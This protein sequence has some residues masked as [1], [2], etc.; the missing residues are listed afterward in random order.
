MLTGSGT[1][2]PVDVTPTWAVP[3]APAPVAAYPTTVGDQRALASTGVDVTALTSIG[4]L[5]ILLGAVALVARRR[6]S[7]SG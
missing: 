3:P 2:V 7:R 6:T 5:S 1:F 4:G